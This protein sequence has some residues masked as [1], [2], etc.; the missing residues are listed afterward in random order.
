MKKLILICLLL[1]TGCKENCADPKSMASLLSASLQTSWNCQGVSAMNAD[2]DSWFATAHLCQNEDAKMKQ[3][4]I[5]SMACPFIVE[6]LRK[7]AGNAIPA[8]WQCDP[9]KIGGYAS[10]ALDAVCVL[11]PF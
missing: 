1:L 6:Q 9:N 4:S 5:S 8:A 11:I 2:L 10:T 7:F 3:G